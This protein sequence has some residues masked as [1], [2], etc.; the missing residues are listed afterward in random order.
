MTARVQIGQYAYQCRPRWGFGS[1]LHPRLSAIL[2]RGRAHYAR[3]LTA[4]AE[5]AP[6]LAAIPQDAAEDSAAPRWNNPF[7]TGLDA[8]ALCGMLVRQAPRLLIEVGSG[9]STRFSRHVITARSLPTRL[10]SIDPQPRAEIDA[11]CDETIRA[12]VETVDPAVFARLK[13]GDILLIDS[14]HRSLENS[15]VTAL[16]LEILPELAPG[17]IVHIHDVYLPYDYPPHAEGLMY[18]EQYLLAALLLGEASW[19]EPILP[20]YFA[21]KD[22]R[23]SPLLEPVW[24]AI[25]TNA[26]PAPCNSFWLT[27]KRRR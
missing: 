12:P 1:P 11:L 18:N 23:L 2:E 14:S 9:H 27:I 4:L 22:P 10:V 7:F 8:V 26:F 15:D 19:L 17:V 16:F 20:C 24:A 3:R 6:L 25:G 5:L 13:P 21:V